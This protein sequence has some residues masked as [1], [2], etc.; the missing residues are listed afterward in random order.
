MTDTPATT[1][2]E[3]VPEGE[4]A[5]F[6]RYAE[7]LRE[8]QRAQAAKGP[9]V[10]RALHAKG[11]AGVLAEFTVLPDVPAYARIGPFATPATYRAYVRFSNGNGAR[12][13]DRKPDVRGIA[14]KLVGV[15]GP[16]IIPGMEGAKTQDFL[17][18]QSRATPFRDAHEFVS[19]V[20]AAA[21][22]ALLVPRLAR[23]L[24]LGR[25]LS[26]LRG[27]LRGAGKPVVSLATTE[28]FSALPIQLGPYAIHYAL[29]PHAGRGMGKRGASPDYLR[30]ELAA[31]LRTADVSYDFRIQFYRDELRTP[32]EDA[33]AVRRRAA[34]SSRR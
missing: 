16:K 27:F 31:R 26:I 28:Y 4:A 1:W 2:K 5:R 23:E 3:N 11:N 32:I 19:L 33:S 15:E 13:S 8:M 30:D 22:P 34:S 14:I 25:T 20:R 18:I 9:G 24:G 12:Q 6:E 21:S 17:L 7:E 29:A 10:S